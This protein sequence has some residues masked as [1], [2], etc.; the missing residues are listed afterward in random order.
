MNKW[1][2]ACNIRCIASDFPTLLPSTPSGFEILNT[3]ES[4]HE[5]IWAMISRRIDLFY[6]VSFP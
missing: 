6:Q 2:D 3:A 1:D 5:F 4:Q